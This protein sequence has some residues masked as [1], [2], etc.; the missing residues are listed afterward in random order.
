MKILQLY[1]GKSIFGTFLITILV[2]TGIL[3]LGNLLKVADLI[4]KGMDPL[5]VLKFFGFLIIGLLEYAIPMAILTATILVFGRLSSD[6][7]IT[8]MRA[9]GVGLI[10]IATPVFF[11]GFGLMVFCLYLQNT[12]IPHYGFAIR[13]LK[14]EITLLAP[15]VLLQPG[16][17]ISFPGYTINF[18]RKEDGVLY[19]IQI[20]QY[21]DEELAS[22]IFAQR[23]LLEF[24]RD[25][26]GFTLK[27]YDGTVEEIPD[28][29]TPQIR[30]TT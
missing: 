7:E 2:L 24:D 14:S 29:A 19:K 23:A 10:H 1:I 12:V 15:D 5:L 17:I 9:C 28:E 13:K 8:G 6:N 3:C 11:I 22:S 18:D 20:N 26:E 27:L 16:E 21:K 4:L 25:R 30:T